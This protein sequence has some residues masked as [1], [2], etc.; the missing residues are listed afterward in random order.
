MRAK[1]SNP[2]S[3]RGC[4]LDCFVARAPRNDG[5]PSSG[6]RRSLVPDHFVLRSVRDTRAIKCPLGCNHHADWP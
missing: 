6:T 2:E 1:R 4:I 3:F 5:C